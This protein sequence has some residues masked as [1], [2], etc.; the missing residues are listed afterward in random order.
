L[1]REGLKLEE[2]L[3]KGY[4]TIYNQ[5]SQEVKDK[6]EATNDWEMT[7]SGQSL[8]ELISKIDL[9]C[10]G[11]DNHKQEVFNLVQA[12]KTLFL[13]SQSNKETVK[14]YGCNF[15]SLWDTM[16]AFRGLSGTHM[17]I[18]DGM[19]K[20][21]NCVVDVNR[22]TDEERRKAE[23]DGS[24]AVKAALLISGANKQRYRQLKNE[25]AN[26]CLLGTD[27]YSTNFDKALCIL[28]NYQVSMSN[29]PFQMPRNE[30]RLAFVQRGGQG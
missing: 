14:E 7:Q 9:I 2:S 11:F 15:S 8:H 16:E 20:D 22:P 12:L 29:R 5:C 6:L 10:M 4:I 18:T 27:Q 3:K 21:P 25:L 1:Q 17:G 28:G 30:S 24:K 23:E 19:F 13:Y 26:N